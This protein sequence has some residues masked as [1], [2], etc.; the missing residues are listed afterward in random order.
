MLYTAFRIFD[1]WLYQGWL[2]EH[3]VV[4]VLLQQGTVCIR[5]S[6]S[7]PGT[8]IGELG[9]YL[10]IPRTASIRAETDCTCYRLKRDEM[11]NMENNHPEVA[12]I[13]HKSLIA[14]LAR[15]LVQTNNL[16]RAQEF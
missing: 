3:G 5:L 2:S 1:E 9:F 13:F 15:R 10:N 14:I 8:V 4:S 6:K 16:L 7:G 12:A 11:T